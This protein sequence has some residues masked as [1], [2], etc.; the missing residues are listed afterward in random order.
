[1]MWIGVLLSALATNVLA[2]PLV[3]GQAKADQL[4]SLEEVSEV[5]A[6]AVVALIQ[7]AGRFKVSRNCAYPSLSE[8]ALNSLR[9]NTVSKLK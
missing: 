8:A 5:D 6:E 4:A 9:K 2:Q 3:L 1:M 7:T